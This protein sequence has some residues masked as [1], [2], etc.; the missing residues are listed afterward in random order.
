MQ[1]AATL[2]KEDH[3][4]LA[5]HRIN[6]NTG[7]ETFDLDIVKKFLHGADVVDFACL[8]DRDNDKNHNDWN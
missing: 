4:K 6:M 5:N 2:T 7:L 3:H 8:I 1:K